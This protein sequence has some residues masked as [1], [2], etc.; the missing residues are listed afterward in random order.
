MD[1]FDIGCDR[2]GGVGGGV[3]DDK[4]NGGGIDYRR[5]EEEQ[6][7]GLLGPLE[8]T[9]LYRAATISPGR[10]VCQPLDTV[11]MVSCTAK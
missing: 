8:N 1:F 3:A 4:C 5:V 7:C 9:M 2:R 6:R 11:V 10:G